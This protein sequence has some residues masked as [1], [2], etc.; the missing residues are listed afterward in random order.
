M[1]KDSA[2]V[3]KQMLPPQVLQIKLGSG[4]EEFYDLV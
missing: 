4:P 1:Y 3:R 2:F